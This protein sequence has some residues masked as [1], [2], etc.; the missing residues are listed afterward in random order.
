[1][2]EIELAFLRQKHRILPLPISSLQQPATA[3]ETEDEITP[4]PP[5]LSALHPDA[6]PPAAAWSLCT[7]VTSARPPLRY[8]ETAE[9][10]HIYSDGSCIKEDGG[11]TTAGDDT[12]EADTVERAGA[13]ACLLRETEDEHSSGPRT[14]LLAR[15]QG[16]QD[17]L[18]AELVGLLL[19][20][21]LAKEYP[22]ARRVIGL[23]DC[24]TALQKVYVYCTQPHL[25]YI[26]DS[27]EHWILEPIHKAIAE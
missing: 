10:V 2:K 13:A 8:E 21:R 18:N 1:M 9:E 19:L 17:S 24:S 27:N 12:A 11:H 15:F 6:P 3:M 14:E 4:A 20:V 23:C 22:A 25:P 16:V 7:A 26:R 5:R